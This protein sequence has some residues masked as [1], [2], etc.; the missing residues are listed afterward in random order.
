MKI[1]QL[2]LG[3]QTLVDDE[4]F[5]KINQWKWFYNS[6]TRYAYRT[7]KENKHVKTIMMARFIMNVPKGFE[8]DHINHDRLDNR[9]CNLRI[10]THKI[11]MQNRLN[12]FINRTH[13]ICPKCRIDK[14]FEEFESQKSYCLECKRKISAKWQKENKEKYLLSQIKYNKKRRMLI[15]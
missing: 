3:K 5:D 15:I 4:D 10:C 11:N 9:K 13:K 14:K 7:K 1:I 12:P 6:Y 8:T 2:N